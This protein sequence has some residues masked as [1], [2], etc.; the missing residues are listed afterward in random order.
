[1]SDAELLTMASER[2]LGRVVLV[3]FPPLSYG[4]RG[5]VMAVKMDTQFTRCPVVVVQGL[6]A[7]FVAIL[8]AEMVLRECSIV[9]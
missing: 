7:R 3:P 8:F 4:V 6:N 1:M 9:G 5:Q 2:L